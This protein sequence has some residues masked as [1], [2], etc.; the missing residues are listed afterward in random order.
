M[1]K[2]MQ[3]PPVLTEPV[4]AWRA[5]GA[6]AAPVRRE[7]SAVR[8]AARSR[9][10]TRAIPSAGPPASGAVE[11]K[12]TKPPSG[13]ICGSAELPAA[14]VPSSSRLAS[15]IVPVCRSRTSTIATGSPGARES[16]AG[17]A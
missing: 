4:S 15:R 1:L 13:L 2:E 6:P 9:R 7:T 5:T 12:A 16:G 8:P 11:V 14:G 3:R 10:K 17:D